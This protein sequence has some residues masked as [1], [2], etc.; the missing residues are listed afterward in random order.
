VAKSAG[1]SAQVVQVRV[2][3]WLWAA[4]FFKTRSLASEAI[5]G[6]KVH[7]NGQRSKPAK[8][9]QVGD[10]LTIRRGFDEYQVAVLALAEKRG[11]ATIAVTLYAESDESKQ[12]RQTL[13]EQRK[14]NS[15]GFV[16]S[17]R[18]NK[19]QRRQLVSFTKGRL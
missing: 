11:S 7:L 10:G 14:L 9:V 15:A 4:R 5:K 2:D 19:K 16:P 13:A 3:K 12:R 18:P 1:D 17:E 6:G 8:M